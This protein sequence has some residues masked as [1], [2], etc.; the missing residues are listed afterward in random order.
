MLMLSHCNAVNSSGPPPAAS[1]LAFKVDPSTAPDWGTIPPVI[2]QARDASGKLVP[3]FTDS[4][5]VTLAVNPANGTLLGTRTVAAVG[6]VATFSDLSIKTAGTGYRL[7]ATATGLTATLSTRFDIT[8]GPPTHLAFTVQPGT[9]VAGTPLS[10]AIQVTALDSLENPASGFTGSISLTIGSGTGTSGAALSGTTTA[11]AAAGVATFSTI[12]LDSIGTGYVL[13]ASTAGLS[14]VTSVPFNVIAGPPAQLAFITQPV[15]TTAGAAIAPAVQVAVRDAVGNPITSYAGTVTVS[16]TTGTGTSGASL[17]GTRTLVPIGGVATYSDLSIKKSGTGYT[18]SVRSTGLAGATS[19]SFD[20]VPGPVSVLAFAVQPATTTAGA[21]LVPAVVVTARDASG[22]TVPSFT[23][24]VTLSIS[25]NPGNGTLSGTT[26]QVADT[27]VAVFGDLSINNAGTGYRLEAAS[28]ALNATSGAF[29]ILA[30]GASRLVFTVQP[31]TTVAGT[32][33]SPAVQVSELD[34]LGNTVSSFAGTVTLTITS[35]AGTAGASLSGTTTVTASGGVA[36][37]STLSIDSAGTGYTLT[38]STTG[39]ADEVSASFNV[40]PGA[41]TRLVFTGQPTSTQAGAAITPPIELTALDA[42]GNAATGFAGTVTVSITTGTGT[43]GANLTGTKSVQAAAGVADFTDL[44]IDL[45]GTGYTLSARSSG[46]TG[47]VSSAFDILIGSVT[48]LVFTQQPTTDT[49]GKVL[50]P[51]VQLTAQD[52]AGN[53]VTGFTGNVTVSIAVN[54]GGGTLAGTATQKAVA[55][56]ATFANLSIDKAGT[57]YRLQGVAG[58][59]KDTSQAFSILAGT[60]AKLGFTAQPSTTTANT[61]MSPSVKVA[62]QD[63]FGNT[64]TS[65]TGSV[66]VAITSGTGTAGATLSGTLSLAATNGVATFSNLSIDKAGTGYTLKATATGLTAATSAAFNINTGAATQLAFT[67]EPPANTAAGATMAAVKV[68]T[69]DGAGNLVTSYSGS[70]TMSFGTNAGSGTLSGTTTVPVVSGVATFSTLSINKSGVGYTL[71]AVATGL[72][73][74]ISTPFNI[75]AGAASQLVFTAQPVTTTAATALAPITVTAKD[76]QG[77]TVTNYTSNVTVSIGVNPSAGTL[78][79]TKTAAAVQGVAT[80]SNLSIDSAGT[81]YR[82]AAV[83]SGLAPDTSSAFSIAAGTATKLVF[84]VQ[85]SQTGAGA[86]ITPAVKVTARDAVGNT[87]TSFV[88]NVTAAFGTNAGGGTLSGTLVKPV[89]SGVATFNDLSIDKLGTGYTLKATATGL[90]AATSATFNIV[91]GSAAQLAFTTQPGNTVAGVAMTQVKVTARDAQG[92]TA[93]GFSGNITVA[94]G[95]NPGGGTLSGTKTVAALA[96]VA[97]FST[98]SID[99]SG[100]GYTLTAAASGLTGATSSTFN[101]TPAAASQLVF[102]IEPSNATAGATITPAVKVGAQDA[103]G[104]VVTSFSGSVTV[105]IEPG[106]GTA[107]ATLSGT[108]TVNAASGVAT[109]STLSIDK[110]GADYHLTATS[111]ALTSGTSAIFAITAGAATHLS[112]DQDP[113]AATAG[114]TITPAV[115][116]SARDAFGN[117]VKNFASSI[118]VAIASGTGTAGAVLSGTN[119][120]APASGVATFADLSIDLTGSGYQLIASAS[121]V[122]GATSATFSIN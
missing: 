12:S 72:T 78:S 58:S 112:F 80:F 103:F 94:I 19:T 17:A 14:Q 85:P 97:T 4:V 66:T 108:S 25:S 119:T 30:G 45:V 34:S 92:N 2:V 36:S 77:N 96:G 114:A 65:F 68:A 37:F 118:T 59:L 8:P 110:A 111:G 21:T 50:T 62:A 75:L 15:T 99:K 102:T 69:L 101:I 64:V 87:A 41:A 56:V 24:P 10:P 121:G 38:A 35:G 11:T 57:G 48:Q 5:T 13:A 107:G 82:L 122:T 32:A 116:V 49:A 40:N 73:S 117:V 115:T 86:I 55:G 84:S 95:A 104:N 3:S 18:L 9:A 93:T 105:A 28:G 6:G 39:L 71:K 44:S 53:T 67:I 42:L 74:A 91:A 60:A 76:A 79:G 33:I 26:T 52:A 47:T 46:I 27:G 43:S 22:N 100:S 90:T 106:T 31:T 16:I 81:G 20:I 83:A 61:T 29:S 7:Q 51:A 120:Q 98:L 23:D 54:P 89:V 63:A 113:T 109:F 1:Q 70:V 88:G